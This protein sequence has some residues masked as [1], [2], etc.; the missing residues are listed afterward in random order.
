[1]KTCCRCNIEKEDH[2]FR[3]IKQ[4]ISKLNSWCKECE[5]TY[6]RERYP[7]QKERKLNYYQQNKESFRQTNKNWRNNNIEHLR[8]YDRKKRQKPQN[9]LRNNV[10]KRIKEL[11][12]SPQSTSK[13]LGCSG[14]FLKNYLEAKF[15]NGMTWDNY[16]FY[17]WHMDHIR[18]IASFDLNNE[19]EVK[20]C[21]HYTNLQPLWAKDNLS[22]GAKF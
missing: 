8:E 4:T 14:Q 21:F 3:S 22:K 15:V 16:G 6:A 1:M 11:I 19:A 2:L 18:P 17:G 7:N 13:L 10:R 9:K 5:N 20:E 12:S